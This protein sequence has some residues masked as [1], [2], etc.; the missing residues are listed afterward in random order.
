MV[1]MT[2]KKGREGGYSLLEL[3][4]AMLIIAILVAV[5]ILMVTGFFSKARETGLQADL[6]SMQSALNT[7][8]IDSGRPPTAD[9]S[10]PPPGES[11]PIDFDASFTQGGK[12]LAFYPD[13]IDKL[14][15]HHDEEVWRIDNRGTVSVDMDPD[16]Y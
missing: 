10:L 13:Y 9:G 6:Q 5:V 16:E 15:K 11:A 12:P 7:Y 14:P 4:I 2:T 1:K 8:M 3:S